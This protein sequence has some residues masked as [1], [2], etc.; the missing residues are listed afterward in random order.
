MGPFREGM[1][2]LQVRDSCGPAIGLR[3]AGGSRYA[4]I[5]IGRSKYAGLAA[6]GDFSARAAPRMGEQCP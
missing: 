3:F 1:K 6:A 5:T 2:A 4:F